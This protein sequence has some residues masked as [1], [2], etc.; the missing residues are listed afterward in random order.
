MPEGRWPLN[1]RCPS[2]GSSTHSAAKPAART[3]PDGRCTPGPAVGVVGRIGARTGRSPKAVRLHEA[4]GLI[5]PAERTAAGY[6][7]SE[8][9]RPAPVGTDGFRSVV[10]ITPREQGSWA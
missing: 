5:E 2:G 7:T 8:P 10:S 9:R 4:H 1:A 3:T 6:L